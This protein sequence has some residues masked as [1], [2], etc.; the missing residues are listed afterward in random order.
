MKATFA[1]LA[2]AASIGEVSAT[3]SIPALRRASSHPSHRNSYLH[4]PSGV[5]GSKLPSTLP[6]APSTTSV[7]I[8]SRVVGLGATSTSAASISTTTGTSAA[9]PAEKTSRSVILTAVRS[10]R[11]FSESVAPPRRRLPPSVATA[12]TA[13]AD[14]TSSR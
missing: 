7:T 1:L 3:V 12:A 14:M 5:T 13:V 6:L 9:G 11:P 2:A 8:S 10:A 4:I